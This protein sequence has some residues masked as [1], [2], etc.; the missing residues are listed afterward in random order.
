VNSHPH[1]NNINNHNNHHHPSH[2][3]PYTNDDNILQHSNDLSQEL[4]SPP[5]YDSNLPTL[6]EPVQSSNI[7]HTNQAPVHIPIPVS[8]SS[9]LY[10]TSPTFPLIQNWPISTNEVSD[11]NHLGVEHVH[12]NGTVP[13]TFGKDKGRKY[14]YSLACE[15]LAS[16]TS[17]FMKPTPSPG[18][19]T[20]PTSAAAAAEAIKWLLPEPSPSA[21][22]LLEH[23]EQVPIRMKESNASDPY[24]KVLHT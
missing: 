6:I 13:M 17:A 10:G 4:E 22:K 14:I 18:L 19:A 20:T 11:D 1:N 9:N 3:L 8:P 24:H 16:P 2:H 15:E 12:K 21:Y 23:Q 5:S 7:N